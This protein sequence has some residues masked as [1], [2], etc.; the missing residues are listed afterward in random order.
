MFAGVNVVAGLARHA[1][2]ALTAVSRVIV[3]LQP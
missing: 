1:S 2:I 3:L